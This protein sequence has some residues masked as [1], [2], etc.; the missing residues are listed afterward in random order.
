MTVF[1][2]VVI[3]MPFEPIGLYFL[4]PYFVSVISVLTERIE[5]NENITGD[6]EVY[7]ILGR[8]GKPL[9]G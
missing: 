9:G 3:M 1:D 7:S 2:K 8:N 6:G 5:E 4:D